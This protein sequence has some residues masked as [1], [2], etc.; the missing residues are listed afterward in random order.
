VLLLGAGYGSCTCLHL[1]ETRVPG[2]PTETNA[3]SVTTAGG[4]PDWITYTATVA[5]AADFAELGAE[6]EAGFPV[7]HGAVGSAA[8]RLFP[9]G[10]IVAFGTPWIRE[11]RTVTVSAGE[12][13][14][15]IEPA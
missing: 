10:A 6:F 7:V 8:A 3:C 15:A 5:A 9:L 13:R 11:R 2:A 14:W 1:A 4:R 12:V